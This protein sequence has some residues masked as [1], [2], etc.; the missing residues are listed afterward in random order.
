MVKE[1]TLFGK[2][3]RLPENQNI[4]EHVLYL[5]EMFKY[6]SEKIEED[7]I[8]IMK[9]MAFFIVSDMHFVG[10]R[11]AEKDCKITALGKEYSCHGS[12]N[13]LTY[14]KEAAK[15]V[16]RLYAQFEDEVG[17]DEMT[18][19]PLFLLSLSYNT[20]MNNINNYIERS[21]DLLE[22]PSGNMTMFKYLDLALDNLNIWANR[23]FDQY[24]E[25]PLFLSQGDS[26]NQDEVLTTLNR[27]FDTI[28]REPQRL[29]S[30]N[31][32]R[33]ID[34]RIA[35]FLHI[36]AI[37]PTLNNN[38]KG[39]LSFAKASFFSNFEQL[40]C[41]A[42]INETKELGANVHNKNYMK[43]QRKRLDDI[44]NGAAIL[45]ITGSYATKAIVSRA[46]LE[47]ADKLA[48]ADHYKYARRA[49]SIVTLLLERDNPCFSNKQEICT[50]AEDCLKMIS[51]L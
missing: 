44:F 32:F 29:D 22:C 8:G 18:I 15:T 16:N 26:D 9:A 23:G 4:E 12:E 14:Y 46:F 3:F 2:T 33:Q 6:F 35:R 20:E 7:E 42:F 47:L 13:I 45:A 1:Y 27:L 25:R 51:E 50:Y 11:G 49:Y 24:Y 28:K 48:D 37:I 10:K 19:L 39:S 5:N 43:Q 36:L 40:R 38:P 34:L 31:R 17:T 30:P 41:N 21:Y